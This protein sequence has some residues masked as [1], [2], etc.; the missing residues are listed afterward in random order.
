MK[1]A[2]AVIALLICSP[3]ALAAPEVVSYWNFFTGGDGVRM[4]QLVQNFNKSHDGIQVNSTTLTWGTPFYTKLHSAVVSG[5]APDVV[6][7]HLSHFPIGLEQGD[8][9]PITTE[10]LNK[11]GLHK[12]QFLKSLIDKSLADSKAYGQPGRLYGVPLDTHTLVLYYN[13]DLLRKAGVLGQSGQFKIQGIDQFSKML[14][15]IKARTDALPIAFASND[16]ATVWRTWYTLF[17]QQHGSLEKNGKLYLKDLDSTGLKSLRAIADWSKQGYISHHTSYPAMVALFVSG[18]AAFMI[19]GD[20]EVPTL[21]DGKKKGTVGFDYGI[22]AFPQLYDNR[23]TWADSHNLAIPAHKGQP[24]S[25]AKLEAVFTFIDY[26]EEH[27]ITWAAGGHI[28]AYQ[29]VLNSTEFKQMVPNNEYTPQAARD[30]V[31]A[32]SLPVFGV[33]SPAYTAVDNFFVPALA[34][35]MTPKAAMAHFRKSLLNASQH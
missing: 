14:K 15:K 19:N 5:N 30:V 31:F 32:P 27:A 9:R 6:S 10:E 18:R 24:M 16:G 8:L 2:I 33:G 7:Y 34:G 28:P 12:N 21:V 35:Q 22:M 23:D 26:V 29:P 17:K 25:P 3:Y 4:Q 1:Y 13:K 11:A 20:W